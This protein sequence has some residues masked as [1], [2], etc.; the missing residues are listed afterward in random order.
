MTVQAEDLQPDGGAGSGLS[1][2]PFSF[3]GGKNLGEK[4][5]NRYQGKRYRYGCRR[6]KTGNIAKQTIDI[7]NIDTTPPEFTLSLEPEWLE[8]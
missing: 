6:D 8:P 1:E 3:D 5:P 7:Q 2:E 4:Q